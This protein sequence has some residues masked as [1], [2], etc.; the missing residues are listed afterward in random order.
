MKKWIIPLVLILVFFCGCEKSVSGTAVEELLQTIVESIDFDQLQSFAEKG[1]DALV[2][3][4]PALKTLTS[5]EDMQELLKEHGLKLIRNYLESTDE[6][7]QANA[8]KLGTILKILSPELSDEVDA[9][10][11]E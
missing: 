7:V 2:E 8:E 3:Q 9:I 6:A 4:F 10:F 11:A 1:A 5:R